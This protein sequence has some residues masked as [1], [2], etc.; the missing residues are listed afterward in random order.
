MLWFEPMWFENVFY[1]H[2]GFWKGFIMHPGGSRIEKEKM[3][4][5]FDPFVIMYAILTCLDFCFS[6]FFYCVYGMHVEV[7]GQ[8]R[9]G[10]SPSTFMQ[11]PRITLSLPD[12]QPLETMSHLANP[13]LVFWIWISLSVLPVSC[14]SNQI[15]CIFK[16]FFFCFAL[17]FAFD[18]SDLIICSSRE[19]YH[20]H[21]VP[22]TSPM[23]SLVAACRSRAFTYAGERGGRGRRTITF[24]LGM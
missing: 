10:F 9:R 21:I 3:N 17:V 8:L 11:V 20:D 16:T 15:L 13:I 2:C 1:A 4:S 23:Q 5:I 24:W 18:N 14:I 7:R 6:F 19:L 12:C 22:K